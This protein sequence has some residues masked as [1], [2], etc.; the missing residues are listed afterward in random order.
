MT[1]KGVE[2]SEQRPIRI[3]ISYSHDSPG[4]SDRVLSLTQQLRHDGLEAAIDQF[5]PFPKQG[6]IRW[7]ERQLNEADFT[8]CV[9]TKEYRISFDGLDTGPAGKGVNWE[10]QTISQFIYEARGN[11]VRFIPVLFAGQE[12]AD[13][14]PRALKPYTHFVLDRQYDELFRLLT[15]QPAVSPAPRGPL[16]TLPVISAGVPD[17]A[18]QLDAARAIESR[19]QMIAAG[20]GVGADAAL[21]QLERMAGPTASGATTETVIRQLVSYISALDTSSTYPWALRLFRGRVVQ[22]LIRLSN[23]KLNTYFSGRAL[24]GV[25]LATFDFRGADLSGVDF[26]GSF[27][28]ECDFRGVT[29]SR[30]TFADCRIRN[31]RF[32]NAFLYDVDFSRADWFNSLGL[33]A[34]Q[35]AACQVGT[36]MKC[37]ATER[38][39]HDYLAQN[40]GI[41]FSSWSPQVQE[42]LRQA[43]AEYLKP[44]GLADAT[45][46]S[47][48]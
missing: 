5:S 42:D 33:T 46:W 45:A 6:W 31:V 9:C 21:D 10:G 3:F 2:A 22:A 47:H 43:W 35:L 30:S 39:M 1:A 48:P 28:I 24:S 40:Y 14:I 12:E 7:M 25:D 19:M 17:M 11:N 16:R 13:V 15:N 44:G 36:L 41:P 8:L 26:S 18:L 4:N 23:G 34:P 20:P 32:D 29:L 38:E 27:M 37:P